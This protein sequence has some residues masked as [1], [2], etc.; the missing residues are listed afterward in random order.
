MKLDRDFLLS[1]SSAEEALAKLIAERA[2]AFPDPSQ[3]KGLRLM[4]QIANSRAGYWA[5]MAHSLQ[6]EERTDG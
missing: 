4:W 5:E 6:S 1:L 2:L 3:T